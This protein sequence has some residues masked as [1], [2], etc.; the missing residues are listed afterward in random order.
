MDDRLKV[1]S[2][3]GQ[4]FS[5]HDSELAVQNKALWSSYLGR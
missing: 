5:E 3:L 1:V 4:M 2:L